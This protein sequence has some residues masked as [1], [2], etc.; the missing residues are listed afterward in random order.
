[1]SQYKLTEARR[2][3]SELAQKALVGEEVIITKQNKPLVRLVP[4]APVVGRRMAGTAKGQVRYL[5]PDFD[6]T[7]VDFADDARCR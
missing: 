3:L 7:P 1:M 2:R 4:I 5:A 6:A